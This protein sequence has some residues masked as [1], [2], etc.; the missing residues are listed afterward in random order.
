MTLF[1]I[2]SRVKAVIEGEV[3]AIQLGES[4]NIEYVVDVDDDKNADFVF[5]EQNLTLSLA[6]GSGKIMINGE[7]YDFQLFRRNTNGTA[8]V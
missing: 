1:N 8:E 3:I 4:G 5:E 7:T 2:G 6:V